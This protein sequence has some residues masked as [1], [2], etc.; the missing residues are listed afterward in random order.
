M[1]I[2]ICDGPTE[3]VIKPAAHYAEIAAAS[4]AMGMDIAN[5]DY[6]EIDT[7]RE[8]NSVWMTTPANDAGGHIDLLVAGYLPHSAYRESLVN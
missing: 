3:N 4:R 7:L 2:T 1:P 8:S 5:D 6:E